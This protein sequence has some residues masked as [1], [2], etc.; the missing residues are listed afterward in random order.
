VSIIAGRSGL[1]PDPLCVL[2]PEL[3]TLFMRKVFFPGFMNVLLELGYNVLGDPEIFY[4]K[5]MAGTPDINCCTT[6]RAQFPL[7]KTVDIG[8]SFATAASYHK[9]SC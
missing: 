4:F 6:Y 3:F 8:K 5:I 2:R 7:L 9:I 1:A